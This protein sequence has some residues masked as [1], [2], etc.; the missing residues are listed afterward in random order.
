MYDKVLYYETN[1][2]NPHYNLAVE[3]ALLEDARNGVLTVYLWRNDN[4]VVIGR[5][6]NAYLDVNVKKLYEEGGTLARRPTGG[7]AVFHDKGNLNFSFITG[8]ESYDV[9]DNNDVILRA[10]RKLGPDAEV[11]GRNDIVTG[12]RKFSGTAY[13]KTNTGALHHGTILISADTSKMSGFL[14]VPPD[15]LEGK[16]VSSVR[17][18]VVNLA[19]LDENID[20]FKVKEAILA[21]LEEKYGKIYPIKEPDK[22]KVEAYYKKYSDREYLFGKNVKLDSR[23]YKRFSWGYAD[24]NFTLSGGV[25]DDIEIFSDGINVDDIE[26]AKKEL[27]GF[28]VIDDNGDLSEVARDVLSLIN[29]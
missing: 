29:E 19:E 17:S 24:V 5:H 13:L 7:G 20:V 14:N 3:S 11:T 16:G 12:G 15:K 10:V 8:L 23:K 1:G 4:T 25:I 22:N 26:K 21:V 28:S 27:T 6:Q 18:R 9:N 2:F